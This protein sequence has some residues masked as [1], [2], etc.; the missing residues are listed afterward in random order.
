MFSATSKE[1][2]VLHQPAGQHEALEQLLP[3]AA[4]EAPNQEEDPITEEEST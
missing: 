4:G 2:T 1:N 3:T